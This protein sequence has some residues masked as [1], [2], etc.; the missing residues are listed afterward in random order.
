MRLRHKLAAGSL[1]V[2]LTASA[3]ADDVVLVPNSNVKG[4]VGGRVRGTI[5]S[6]SS[7]NVVVKLGA[8]TTTVPTGEIASIS[9]TG[10]PP[11]MVQAESRESAGSLAEAADLYKKAAAEAEKPFIKQ[12]A[13]FAQANAMAELALMDASKSP[14][15]ITLLEAFV[16]AH[17]GGRHAV[18]AYDN[19]ARLQLQ[20]EDFAAVEKTLAAMS[21]LPQSADRAAVL[22]AKVFAKQGNFD[23]AV[24]E[25]D[26][27]IKNGPEG[28]FRQR[29]AKLAKAEGLAGQKKYAEAEELVRSVIKSSPPE[30]VQTQSA[31]Y[32][33]L[34]DCLR[35]ANKPKEALDAYLHTDILY[36]KDKEQHPRALAQISHLWRTLR[37]DDRADE[38]WQVL[39]KEYPNSQWL[40]SRPETAQ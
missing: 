16:R 17:A 36:S 3:M 37:R 10:Q 11:V 25:Y 31:A 18:S 20:K 13:L 32:N 28:S 38:V 33:T 23:K 9:Y 4:A 30:D 24:A 26:Q 5:D 40:A 19:L 15:A 35:A 2:L 8:T 6:E 22:R 34:G 27:L 29:E 12:A 1:T 21:K 7:T 39:K 14:E